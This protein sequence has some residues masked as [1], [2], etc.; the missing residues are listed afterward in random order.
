MEYYIC[1]RPSACKLNITTPQLKLKFITT[2]KKIQDRVEKMRAAINK[3][4]NNQEGLAVLSLVLQATVLCS[5]RVNTRVQFPSQGLTWADI[6]FLSNSTRWC[7]SW[8]QWSSVSHVHPPG[9]V[10][11]LGVH[12]VL[13]PP[14]SEIFNLH[15]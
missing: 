4:S 1:L 14:V 7:K 15:L 6:S 2:E 8:H 3:N 12:L 11:G 5:Q 13:R 10:Q 9:D